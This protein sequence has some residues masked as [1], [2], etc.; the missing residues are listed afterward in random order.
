MIRP[1]TGTRHPMH[2]LAA[3]FAAYAP[4]DPAEQAF[5]AR[6][7]ALAAQ[8]PRA[9]WRDTFSPGHF[10]GSA[11]AVS[12]RQDKV[13]LMQHKHLHRWMQ[14]GGHADGEPDLSRVSLREAAEE[15][16]FPEHAF[17]Q[18]GAIFDID[19]HPI[20]ANPG[21]N[22]PAHEHFDVRY[23]LSVDDAAILPPNPERLTLRWLTLEEAATLAAGERG[24]LRMLDKVRATHR[25]AQ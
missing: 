10:T 22:E 11:L 16:G 23:L 17:T 19:I 5:K 18:H 2:I 15:S 21:K 6:M 24:L 14:F 12:P 7:A 3:A 1:P 8:E 20:P 13:L 25:R 4:S 9:L